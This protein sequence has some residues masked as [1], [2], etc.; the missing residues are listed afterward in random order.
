MLWVVLIL[1]VVVSL[2][3]ENLVPFGRRFFIATLL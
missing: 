2:P 1:G 3:C